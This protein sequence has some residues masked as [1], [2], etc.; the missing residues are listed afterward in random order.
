MGDRRRHQ[1]FVMTDAC[2]GTFQ[3]LE[4]VT[5]EDVSA[6]QL[7]LLSV[8]PAKPGEVVSVE[9]PGEQGNGN[10]VFRGQVAESRPVMTDGSLRHRVVVKMT[11]PGEESSPG[12]V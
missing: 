11:S 10:A 7:R 3:L 1:R 6:D 12:D 2:E 9:V 5:I 8:S 4:D